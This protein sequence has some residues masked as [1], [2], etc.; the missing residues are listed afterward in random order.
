MSQPQFQPPQS[1][2]PPQQPQGPPQ[3]PQYNPYAGQ[4][5]VPQQPPMPPQPPAQAPGQPPV[6]PP[7]QGPGRPGWPPGPPQ[8][9]MPPQG[10]VPP[11]PAQP[12]AQQPKSGNPAGAFVLAL[13]VS[14]LITLLYAGGRAAALDVITSTAA[15]V[16]VWLL[17]TAV[18]GAVVGLVAGKVGGGSTGVRVGAAIVGVLGAFFGS[19]NA[20]VSMII[21]GNDW[22]NFVWMWKDDP[23]FPAVA[24]GSGDLWYLSVLS[25]VIGGGLAFG[26]AY[27]VGKQRR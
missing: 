12:G 11:F 27:A 26:L 19:T 24:W 13:L 5:G 4:P 22:S 1:G 20:M 7:A 9:G 2:Q 3:P 21:A 18:N 8:P 23:L 16:T 17:A 10:G 6:Q 15:A 14:F 25:L